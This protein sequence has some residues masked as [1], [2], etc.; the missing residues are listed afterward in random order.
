[1]YNNKLKE[2][3]DINY[4]IRKCCGLCSHG[5][6][7]FLRSGNSYGTCEIHEYKH[8][9]HT[10]KKRQLSINRDGYCDKFEWDEIIM[11]DRLGRWM[12]FLEGK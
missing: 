5:K 2:L 1:M 10:G 11:D 3:Q 12:E 6:F 4:V 8:L 9:K 7:N